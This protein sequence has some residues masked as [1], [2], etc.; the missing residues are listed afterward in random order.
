MLEPIGDERWLPIEELRG[1]YAVSGQGRVR[2]LDRRVQDRNGRRTRL[3]RG[4]II[5]PYVAAN[6]YL[7]VRLSRDGVPAPVSRMV[8]RLVAEAFLGPC[9][10]GMEVLHGPG[11]AQDNR[12][13]NLSYGTHSQ[14]MFDKNRDGTDQHRNIESCPR[15]HLL[16]EPNLVAAKARRGI[17]QCLACNRANARVHAYRTRHGIELDMKVEADRY[18][19]EIVAGPGM[20][21]EQRASRLEEVVEW[22]REYMADKPDG[23]ESR[24]ALADCSERD[25]SVSELKRARARLG[26]V[27]VR[28]KDARG[29]DHWRWT[30]PET[31]EERAS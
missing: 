30:W 11:G 1:L 18:Y 3:W 16:R 17:R 26:V 15:D 29:H 12:V 20:P 14:N 13:S 23:A 22:M 8:H 5:K 21:A 9:P 27:P 28:F 24:A 4:Q 10:V 19:A 25:F 2:S 31:A 7:Q 6:G